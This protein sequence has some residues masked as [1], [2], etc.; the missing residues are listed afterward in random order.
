MMD[1]TKDLRADQLNEAVSSEAGHGRVVSPD[2]REFVNGLVALDRSY[3]QVATRLLEAVLALAEFERGSLLTVAV[4]ADGGSADLE[5]IAA[6]RRRLVEGQLQ[7]TDVQ[8]AEF[9]VNQSVLARSLVLDRPLTVA[10]SLLSGGDG[11][12]GSIVCH[13]FVLTPTTKGVLYLESRSGELSAAELKAVQTLAEAS[14]PLVARSFL[15]NECSRLQEVTTGTPEDRAS[16]DDESGADS[17]AAPEIEVEDFYG[18]VGQDDK[19]AKIFRVIDKIKDNDLNVCIIGESGTGKELFARAIHSAGTR[20]DRMFVG[21]NC[22]AI[23]ETLLESE[24]FGHVRGAFTGA[25]DDRQ[26]LFELANGGTLFLDEIGDMSES[27]QR[28]LLRV[29]QEGLI[30]PIGSKETIAV[31][32]RVI[33]ASNR[34]LKTLVQKGTFRADLF[35]RLNVITIELPPLRERAAD[36]PLLVERFCA[37]VCAAEGVVRRFSESAAR[38]LASYTW[39]GN[40][41]ELRNVVRRAMLTS[42]RRLVARKEVAEYLNTSGP[43]AHSGKNIERDDGQIVLRIPARET[44]NEIIDECERVVLSHALEECAWNKSKVTKVLKIPR[45]SLYNKIAKYDLKREWADSDD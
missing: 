20:S 21:E 2:V 19:L 32:V 23:S 5:T 39:P 28:K 3:E 29:L 38:A 35:Y 8:S 36:I 6:R 22:G 44:F 37:E 34:D 42:T 31:D 24:L 14:L 12:Q 41:R 10:D 15:L 13:P 26:G 9:S 30:R 18:I 1:D 40:V 17:E 45:Q 43:V 16:E 4:A 27:M 7:W 25:D 11:R 33:S